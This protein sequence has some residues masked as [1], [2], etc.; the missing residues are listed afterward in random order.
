MFTIEH[1]FDYSAIVVMDN[2]GS[3]DDVELIL[4]ED[5]VYI[6]QY[7][8]D[9]NFNIVVISPFM[10]KEIVSA[11]DKAEGAYITNKIKR[12]RA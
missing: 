10:L 6:R 2:D 5:N 4:D 8:N 9:E 3:H 7:D 12:K 1:E 11:Y